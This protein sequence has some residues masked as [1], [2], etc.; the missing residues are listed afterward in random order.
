MKILFQLSTVRV[1]GLENVCCVGFVANSI[2]ICVQCIGIWSS[3]IHLEMC[4]VLE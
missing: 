2:E 1:S 4:I 3:E